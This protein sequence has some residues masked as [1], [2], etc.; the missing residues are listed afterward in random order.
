MLSIPVNKTL[1]WLVLVA[2]L[3]T[4]VATRS[5]WMPS[6]ERRIQRLLS[7]LAREVSLP[8]ND[9]PLADLAAAN[10]IAGFFASPFRINVTVAGGPDVALTERS[11]LVQ[12][13]LAARNRRTAIR[14]ELLDPQTVELNRTNA[15]IEATARAQVGGEPEP[16]VAE[17]R[18]VLVKLEAG[19]RVRE[20]ENV[21]TF[22]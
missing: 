13:V 15:V 17:L 4:A 3:G 21:R 5:A 14:V 20:V 10:R 16:V 1:K 19:W 6:D 9:K 22:E 8:A 11:E 18:F 12:T 2:L 7:S